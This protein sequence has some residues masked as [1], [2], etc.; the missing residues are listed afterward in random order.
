MGE[1]KATAILPLRLLYVG[2]A[3]SRLPSRARR[4]RISQHPRQSARRGAHAP[5]PPRADASPRREPV[6]RTAAR[7]DIA[8]GARARAPWPARLLTG[9][10]VSRVTPP[11]DSRAVSC[12]SCAVGR[13]G[14]I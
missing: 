7:A 11:S 3:S 12:A 5:T 14:C 6:G 2:H 13:C 4:S 9:A 10:N 1:I 8:A